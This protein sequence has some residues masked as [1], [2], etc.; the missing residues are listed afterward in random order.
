MAIHCTEHSPRGAVGGAALHT[1]RYTHGGRL[2][3][4]GGRM[5]GL[6]LSLPASFI[7]TLTCDGARRV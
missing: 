5:K 2:F 4:G 3:T 6:V 7:A 1:R